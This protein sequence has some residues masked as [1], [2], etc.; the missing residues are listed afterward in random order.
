MRMKE[1]CAATGLTDR[2]VRLYIENGLVH[3]ERQTSYSGRDSI[4]FSQHDLEALKQ[5]AILRKAD[6]SI[7]QISR[8]QREPDSIGEIIEEHRNRL[9]QELEQ[10]TALLKLID[11]IKDDKSN[12]SELE[13]LTKALSSSAETQILPKEDNMMTRHEMNRKTV[14]KILMPIT[15]AASLWGTIGMASLIINVLRYSGGIT[16]KP[17]G[18][19]LY[20]NN[21]SSDLLIRNFPYLLGLAFFVGMLVLLGL[22]IWRMD[23]RLLLAAYGCM[24]VGC[25]II[26]ATSIYMSKLSGSATVSG[27]LYLA[28]F[29]AARYGWL[30]NSAAFMTGSVFGEIIIRAVKY[31]PFVISGILGVVSAAMLRRENNTEK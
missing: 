3:P 21:F 25:V 13:S 7:A 12:L 18:G 8:M 16:L 24:L 6:F 19:Y 10:K 17:G 20:E 4:S 5:I 1:I 29:M 15:L 23:K 28:E 31:V 30:G 22:F 27:S 2:A 14:R 11:E 26:G 9:S